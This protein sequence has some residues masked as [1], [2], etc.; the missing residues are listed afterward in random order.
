METDD[1]VEPSE[2]SD[3][4]SNYLDFFEQENLVYLAPFLLNE[5]YNKSY[6]VAP[7]DDAWDSWTLCHISGDYTITLID[8]SGNGWNEG[9]EFVMKETR[10]SD[11]SGE[12]DEGETIL[13]ETLEYTASA[14]FEVYLC[15]DYNYS[16]EVKPG[17]HWNNE[18]AWTLEDGAGNIIASAYETANRPCYIFGGVDT[19]DKNCASD[20]SSYGK[21]TVYI[22][23]LAFFDQ[24]PK[25]LISF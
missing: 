12:W 16:I 11:E 6:V 22:F 25:K 21:A 2:F 8:I 1:S 19:Q 3:W 7:D 13:R 17:T 9:Q 10:P 20:Y 18:V 5:N 24:H 14:T 23:R 4:N 15:Q